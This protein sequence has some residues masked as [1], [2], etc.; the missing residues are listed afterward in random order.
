LAIVPRPYLMFFYGLKE[1]NP[2]TV[3]SRDTGKIFG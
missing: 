2:T 3:C 1:I